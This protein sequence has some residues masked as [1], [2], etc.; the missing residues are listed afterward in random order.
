MRSIVVPVSFSANSANAARY[1]AD[2]AVVIGA[3]IH[4]IYVFQ[5]P[6]SVSVVPMP[7]SVFKELRDSG[8]EMLAGLQTELAIRTSGK[9]A[10]TTAM[11]TGVVE[12]KIETYCKDKKPLLVVMGATG[13][14][15][16]NDL[17]GSTVV[18]ETRRLPY[19]ILVVP[20]A[21][22]FHA[23]AKIV[24]AC[25]KE[26]IDS[27]MPGTLPFLKELSELLGAR[28]EVLHVLTDGE[29]SAAEA[30]EE[31]N[32]WKKEVTAFNPEIHFIRRPKVEEGI[33]DY[34]EGHGADWVM[35]FPKSHPVLE[36]HRSRSKQV[37]RHCVAP[38]MSVHE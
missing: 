15:L 30:I 26:D 1:A 21:A 10:I 27:G 32:V 19:P 28:L 4:L 11:E 23:V 37:I 33:S 24:V 2:M 31:Y 8:V 18:R 3:D 34:L 35:V 12:K 29:E 36:F 6:V 38:V 9:V 20:Q 13:E 17:S 14:L 16:Q 22:K 7:E 25:D 5:I